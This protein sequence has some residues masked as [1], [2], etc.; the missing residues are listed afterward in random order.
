MSGYGRQLTVAAFLVTGL[1]C[2]GSGA[3]FAQVPVAPASVTTPAYISSSGAMIFGFTQ[4]GP[5]TL[6]PRDVA[7]ILPRGSEITPAARP[8]IE[9]VWRSSPIFRRQCAR[10][11]EA[12]VVITLSL[13]YPRDKVTANAET[14]MT[15]KGGLRAHVRLRAAD[16]SVTEYL[17]HEFEHVLEQIDGVDLTLAVA[18]RVHGARLVE[19]PSAFETS[20]AIAVGRAVAREVEDNRSGK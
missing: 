5:D 6:Q 14:V 12:A 13:D 15:R 17:A 20:R 18:E 4:Q 16:I 10:L 11:V 8:L 1:L 2:P 9:K 3:V 7:S 19:R